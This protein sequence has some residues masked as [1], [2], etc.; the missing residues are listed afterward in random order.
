MAV[1]LFDKKAQEII[2]MNNCCAAAE[3]RCGIFNALE[4]GR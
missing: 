2:P 4:G 1:V 3:L